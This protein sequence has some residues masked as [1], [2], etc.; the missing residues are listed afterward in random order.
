MENTR[1]RE[2]ERESFEVTGVNN[3]ICWREIS[4]SMART[5]HWTRV[6]LIMSWFSCRNLTNVESLRGARYSGLYPD[7]IRCR[8]KTPFA[9]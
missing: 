8:C 7:A 4:V 1:E 9:V 2:S 3:P 6:N 5:S